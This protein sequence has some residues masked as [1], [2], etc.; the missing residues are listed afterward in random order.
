MIYFVTVHL[1]DEV[2]AGP[3]G[4]TKTVYL[5]TWGVDPAEAERH[6]RAYCLGIGV[7]VR[8]CSKPT[9]SQNQDMGRLTFPEQV[10]GAPRDLVE[11]AIR[12]HDFGD[13]I[14]NETLLTLTKKREIVR[15]GLEALATA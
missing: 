14:T 6:A 11:R 3:L 1:E 5:F 7:R 9:L 15:R 12:S 8:A 13:T 2:H 4:F 10:Y